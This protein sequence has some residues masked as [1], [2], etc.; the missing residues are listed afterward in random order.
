MNFFTP[1]SNFLPFSASRP[2][3]STSTFRLDASSCC[4]NFCP[5]ETK[6]N[7][8][9]H[10]HSEQNTEKWKVKPESRSRSGSNKIPPTTSTCSRSFEATP[11]RPHVLASHLRS[12][13]ASVSPHPL[14]QRLS[15]LGAAWH[16][17]RCR[18]PSLPLRL[19]QRSAISQQNG[20]G[21]ANNC[22]KH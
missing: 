17:P 1:A 16:R 15:G 22:I 18:S 21:E 7:H 5:S 9:H 8:H 11:Q 12:A 6:R 20:T 4:A 19:R 13:S 10:H 14:S 2:S 3:Y